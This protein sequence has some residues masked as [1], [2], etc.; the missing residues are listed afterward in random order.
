MSAFPPWRATC[1]LALLVGAVA[2]A[3][4]G[5]DGPAIQEVSPNK[6]ETNVAGDAPVR[7]TFNH[8]MDHA[9]VESRWRLEPA[10][11][12]CD[13]TSCPISWKGRV[14]SLTHPGHQFAP[15]TKYRVTLRSGYRDTAGRVEG[16]E[17]FW[18]FTSEG[19]PSISSVTPGDKSTGV[20]VDADIVIQ[21]TRNVLVPTP[22]QVTVSGA[23]DGGSQAYRAAIAPDDARKL[24]VS[25]LHLLRPRTLYTIHVGAGMEDLHHNPVGTPHDFTFT[26]GALDLTRSVAFL[27]RDDTEGTSSRVAEL[28][29]PPGVN[30]P[31]PSLRLL[32]AGTQPIAS[33]AWASDSSLLYVLDT[34]GMLSVAPLDGSL[35]TDSGVRAAAIAANPARDE[36]AY[37]SAAGALHLWRRGG[38]PGGDVVV[39]QAGR[40]A[41]APVWSGDGRRLAFVTDGGQGP[42]LRV[43][44]RET[45]SV[46]DVPGVVPS[47]SGTVFAWSFD[48]SA[49]AFTRSTSGPEVWTYRPLAAQGNGLAR[50]GALQA[51]SLA[52]SSDG[53]LVFASG[54]APGSSQQLLE[55]ALG[56]PVDGQ[57]SGFTAVRGTKSGDVQ[58]IA[59]AF[60][61]RVAF[62]RQAA[63]T[64]QLWIMNNDGTGV[65]QMTFATYDRDEK[66]PSSGIDQPRWSPGGSGG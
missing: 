60:D 5:P 59:P 49:L 37:V 1:L 36:L 26:T 51:Q 21:L 28:R 14:F 32:F 61:R 54:T 64:P 29:P 13:P 16:L 12:G 57:A 34:A 10:I 35:A 8:D 39:A 63:G 38:L 33:F 20:A 55:R 50:I 40:V 65:S 30:A 11:E 62:V 7:V 66:L 47:A 23:G 46:S 3:A 31:A 53:S 44:D 19:A 15:S 18:E 25:P 9:S 41:G 56:Q 2:L 6:N 27:V 43:L 4:C 24:V 45:L 42:V 22:D 58:P 48:G 52:W 17:H